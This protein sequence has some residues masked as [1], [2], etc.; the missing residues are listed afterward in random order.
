MTVGLTSNVVVVMMMTCHQRLVASERGDE[1]RDRRR[2][3]KRDD[4]KNRQREE[5]HDESA[6]SSAYS[7]A[8]CLLLV[9]SY[10]RPRTRRR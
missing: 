8:Y 1:G 2:G 6:I 4:Q 7:I 9:H 10:L 5:N 3:E